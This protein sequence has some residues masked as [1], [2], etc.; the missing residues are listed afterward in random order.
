M[1]NVPQI[2]T[3]HCQHPTAPLLLECPHLESSPL[4]IS[5]LKKSQARLPFTIVYTFG[6]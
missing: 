6:P 5:T 2:L 4:R 3:P 1:H